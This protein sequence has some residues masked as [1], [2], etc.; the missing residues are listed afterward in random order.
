M[1][2]FFADVTIFLAVLPV[3]CSFIA[4]LSGNENDSPS[5]VQFSLVEFFYL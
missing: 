5:V 3:W 4:T 2:H 1:Q